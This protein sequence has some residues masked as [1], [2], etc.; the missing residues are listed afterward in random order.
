MPEQ[1]AAKKGCVMGLNLPQAGDLPF[2]DIPPALSQLAA[3]QA[4]LMARLIIEKD[5]QTADRP[6]DLPDQLLTVKEAAAELGVKKDWLYRQVKILP[7][8]RRL[9]RKC[10]RFSRRG[11][12]AWRDRKSGVGPR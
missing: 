8:A 2:E 6:E 10:L 9:S 5:K 4:Q 7:F 1:T 11:L 12:L 3:L